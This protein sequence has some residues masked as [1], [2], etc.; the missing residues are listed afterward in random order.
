MPARNEGRKRRSPPGP[1]TRAARS[2]RTAPAAVT[3]ADAV[4]RLAQT[5]RHAAAI[6]TA[7]AALDRRRLGT[8]ERLCL[9]DLRANSLL[10]LG[11]FEAATADAESM[12]ELARASRQQAHLAQALVRRSTLETRAGRSRDALDTARDALAAA[13]AANDPR[14]EVDT[15]IRWADASMRMREAR[16]SLVAAQEAAR[17]AASLGLAEQEGRAWWCVSASRSQLGQVKAADAAARKALAIARRCGDLVGVGNALNMLTFN[18]PDIAKNLRLLREAQAAFAAAGHTERL[19]MIE[20]NLGAQNANLG[21]HRRAVRH[22]TRAFEAY[23]RAGASAGPS[24]ALALR[25]RGFSQHELGHDTE[26][27]ADLA[28]SLELFRHSGSPHVEGHKTHVDAAVALWKG[29]AATALRRARESQRSIEGSDDIAFVISADLVACEAALAAGEPAEALAASIHATDLHRA[30]GLED[31][32]GI[33]IPSLWWWHREALRANGR[34]AGA[35]RALAIAY[36]FVTRAIDR[37]TDEGLRR[38][39]LDKDRDVREI[40]LATIAGRSSRDRRRPRHLV[41][42]SSLSEPFERLVDTGL[43]MNELRSRDALLDFLLDEATELS[44]AERVLIVHDIDGRREAVRSLVPRD[45]DAPAA[46]DAALPWI[47]RAARANSALLVHAPEDATGLA[48]RSIIVAPLSVRNE[49]LAYLYCDIDGAFGRFHEADRNLLAMLASQAAIALDNAQWS[50][51]LE[52]KV[53]QRTHEL[54]TSHRLLEQR[55]S[56]LAVINEIQQGMSRELD[57]R[58]IVDLVGDRLRSLFHT[59]DLAIHW[60]DEADMV[61]V[62]YVYEHGLR[63]PGRV[64]RHKEDSKLAHAM[65]KGLPVVM[66]NRAAMDA[67][68]ISTVEG[69]DASLACVFVP[70]MLGERLTGAISVE[71]FEREDAFGEAEISLLSTIA[72]SMA[73]ALENAR[74]LEATQRREREAAALAEVGRDLSSSLDLATVM[75]RI[76]GHARDLLRAGS[77]AIFLPNAGTPTYR[78]IVAVG[79]NAAALEATTVEG[80]VGIIGSLLRSGKAEFINDAAADPRAVPIP[81]TQPAS[82]ERL[83]V[84]PLLG[85]DDAVEGAMAVW[86]TGGQPFDARDLEFLSGLSRQASVALRNAQLFNE[87]ADALDQQRASSEVLAVISNSIADAQPVFETITR[88]CQRLFAGENAGLTLLRDDGMLDIGAYEGA[89]EAELRGLFPQPLSHGSASGLAIL[90]QRVLVY[91]DIERSDMPERSRNGC[92]AIGLRSMIFAPMM[93][94]GRALGTLWV[95]RT[96]SGPF[97]EKQLALLRSFAGQAVVAIQNVR[98]FNEA[99]EARAAAEAANEAKSAF[100]ATMSHEIRT[101]MNAVI[102]M[103]GLL[104]DTPL[105]PEQ[106]DYVSTIRESGDALLTIINDILDFSK[107]EAGR[108]DIE[109]APFDLRDCVESALDLISARA[110][111]KH[112]DIAYLFE[113]DV[114]AAIAGDVTRLRQVILNLMSNAVKFTEEGEVVV[115]VTARPTSA[116]HAQ[117]HFRV[118]DTGIGLSQEAM[119]RLF[120]SFSQADSSTTRKYGGTGLGLAISKRLAEL[121]GGTMWCESGGPGHGSTFHFTIE[122]PV[123]EVPPARSHSITGVQP[124]L[125]GKRMLVVDDNA[126]N[127][128]VLTLQAVKW[129]MVARDTASPDEAIAWLTAGEHFDLAVTDMH[130]PQMDG[131]ALARRMR[132]VRPDLPRVLWSSLGRREAGDDDTLFAAF[133][134]KPVR[135][136]HLFDTLVSL[137]VRDVAPRSAP[138]VKAALDPDLARRHPLRILLAEDNVV[139]QKLALRL[140]QQMGYRADLASNGIEAIEAVERQ[141]YDVILMDVQMPEMDGLEATR[142]ISA[143]WAA[144]DRPRIV[145]MTANA[146]QGDREA[147]LAAGMDDYLTKPIRVDALMDALRQSRARSVA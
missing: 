83:M 3:A 57:F 24:A 115:T 58:A 11:Q 84:V 54:S 88:R 87:T 78:A 62:L 18:E 39:F 126:T 113:G 77:S 74:L 5:G 90:E 134:A 107:I 26:A 14:I 13:R 67:L 117:L 23:Q 142:R 16:P 116:G 37:V 82:G 72:S 42:A 29:D 31:L 27:M 132:E 34:H 140:L 101:P 49:S 28:R 1:S 94:G 119:G 35:R 51:G 114:P 45:E 111:E 10:A 143:R 65:Q 7:S 147:C 15:L 128:R 86:R 106:H 69:T 50:E 89:G 139:N 71:S 124:A 118:Q 129:G 63:L 79:D 76:A 46:F 136:S 40:V 92:R 95:G 9:L 105:N 12:L 100:L 138:Q 21:L 19:A 20:H 75:N 68:G 104:L 133:L 61:H 109:V 73:V 44:G 56:E 102:G 48:Q 108:M 38:N 137:L 125:A 41:G 60:R 36:R 25:A 85:H 127:R 97:S 47:D 99:Q 2:R 17:S 80:G 120:R 4:A 22:Y 55:V 144:G 123:A 59:G 6:E 103:S 32:Q 93:S 135:Q 33:A 130:M 110:V 121:M 8:R 43:R 53:A 91:P 146:M 122:A 70:M 30:R 131:V 66:N 64:H 141:T 145:A 112:L 96:T 52:A 98:L 81:G